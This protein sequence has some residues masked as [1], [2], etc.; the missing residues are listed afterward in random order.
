MEFGRDVVNMIN[1]DNK[2]DASGIHWD[3]CPELF[4]LTVPSYYEN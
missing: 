1:M 2:Q 4:G 3:I